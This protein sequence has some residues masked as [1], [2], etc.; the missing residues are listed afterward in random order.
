MDD[1]YLIVFLL[2]CLV[3]ASLGGG[4]LLAHF[5]DKQKKGN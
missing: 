4:A 1:L 5:G 3:M 2:I